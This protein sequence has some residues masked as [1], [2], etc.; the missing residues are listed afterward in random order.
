MSTSFNFNDNKL[1]ALLCVNAI[2]NRDKVR[3]ALGWDLSDGIFL[4]YLAAIQ[5]F[6]IHL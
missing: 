1:I 3:E 5:C 6:E 2:L 4:H